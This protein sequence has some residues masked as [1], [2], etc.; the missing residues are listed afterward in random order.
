MLSHCFSQRH[1]SAVAMS[2]LQVDHFLL[3]K[4]NHTISKA[5]LLL[6]TRYIRQ[7]YAIKQKKHMS[8]SMESLR[9]TSYVQDR[10]STPMHKQRLNAVLLYYA[11]IHIYNLPMTNRY[12][13]NKVNKLL[14]YN[15]HISTSTDP[16]LRRYEKWTNE[17]S[18]T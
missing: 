11:T 12:R 2:H 14:N 6:S 4:A 17:E 5:T 3:C 16:I 8:Y 10:N 18:K 9:H 13:H 7:K 1:V 15:F